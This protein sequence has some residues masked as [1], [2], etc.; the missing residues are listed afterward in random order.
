MTFLGIMP[1]WAVSAVGLLLTALLAHGS[2]V[3]LRKRVPVRWVAGLGILRLLAIGVFLACLLR[4]V[5]LHSGKEDSREHLLI[6]LDTSQSMD[7]AE[8]G[9]TPTRLQAAVDTLSESGLLAE[10]S[11]AFELHWF[12]VDRDAR[13]VEAQAVAGL[14]PLGDTTRLAA[15]LRS[16][17]N[18]YRQADPGGPAAQAR[19]QVLLVTDGNDLGRQNVV[20]TARQFGSAVHAL[21]PPDVPA[22]EAVASVTIAGVQANSR[23]MLGSECRFRSTLRAGSAMQGPVTVVLSEDGRPVLSRE[24]SF[25]A[26]ERE[27]HV[28]L[29]YR[30]TS[31]GV[32]QYSLA[33]SPAGN[34]ADAPQDDG[35]D[36]TVDVVGRSSRVLILE[37]AWRWDFKYLRRVLE[38]DPSFSFAS[39]LSRG[40]GIYMQFAEPDLNVSLGGFPQS[41]AELEWF[42]IFVLGDVQ[43]AHWPP[44]LAPAIHELVVE[45]GK[46]LVIIAGPTVGRLAQNPLIEPLLPVEI[47]AQSA[48]PIPGPV[49]VRPTAAGAASAFFYTPAGADVAGDGPELPPLD[50]VYPPLRKRPAATILLEAPGHSNRYGK[51]IVMAEHTVGRGR[52]LYIGTDTL[53]KWQT[54]AP[55]DE[56]GNSAHRT[57]WQQV[58]RALA[59]TRT[60]DPAVGLWLQTD[61]TEYAAGDVIRL[62][63]LLEDPR[64]GS[65]VRVEAR[66]SVPGGRELP[67]ALLP[68]PVRA[69]RFAAEFEVAAPGQYAIVA[70]AS[71]E[72]RVIA[73]TSVSVDID[74]PAGEMDRRQNDLALLEAI[75]SASGGRIVEPG[76]STTWPRAGVAAPPA[77]RPVVTTDLWSDLYLLIALVAILTVDWLLRLLHGFV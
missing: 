2:T 35:Y 17:W 59:P 28:D 65:A 61:R 12:A 8:P 37:D 77:V 21:A 11:D 13:P 76:D 63:A 24:V 42:D 50:Q 71:A 48:T 55:P 57:F 6:L 75:T 52:V 22:T 19:A 43:P 23:V 4:P 39:F 36:L 60:T 25:G 30:P 32:R 46:S 7:A 20:E 40:T 1:G 53:W 58:L 9:S 16:A 74:P 44:T 68:D 72:G 56:A 14:R 70:T 15:G 73:E 64:R 45:Q 34:S 67:V 54:M 3:L 47:T 10:L 26:G 18:Y 69:G 49:D 62:Q 33:V 31:P 66:V 5:L 38:D 41:R 29:A 27:R 51:L